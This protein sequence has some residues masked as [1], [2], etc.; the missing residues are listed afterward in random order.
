MGK[1][2]SAH[3]HAIIAGQPVIPMQRLR[4]ILERSLIVW[5]VLSS[6]A[7]LVWGQQS[8]SAA[9]IFDIV[10]TWTMTPAIVAS[11]FCIGFLLPRDELTQTLSRWPTVLGGCLTQYLSMPLLAF[12]AAQLFPDSSPLYTGIILTGA[13]PGAM[14]SNVLTLTAR[15]NVSYSIS[16]TTTATLISPFA[17]PIALLLFLGVKKGPDPVAVFLNLLQVVA[18]PVVTGFLFKLLLR[19]FANRLL[20]IAAVL[21]NLGILWIIAV[22]IGLNASR[23]NG[24]P[25][26][27]LLV[28][29]LLNV[30]GYVAG[31]T[32][33]R[34]MRLDTRKRRA[35][36]LEIGMQ[37]AGVGTILALSLFPD[38]AVAIPTAVYTFG[39]MF[40][41]TLLAS[42]WNSREPVAAV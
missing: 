16:L 7:A 4:R 37:N 39:C 21:A 13:V 40:T 35:L 25:W 23:L 6:G 29:L 41:G 42:W 9:G 8:P 10:K 14:A 11:M 31:W 38:P 34:L 5:L 30:S 28:L 2:F 24:V 27:L 33:S 17:V 1:I 20:D 26:Q 36:T 3:Q 15:G 22:A 32:G 12:A 18:C 19:S